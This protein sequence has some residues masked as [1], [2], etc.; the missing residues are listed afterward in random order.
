[1]VFPQPARDV[2]SRGT[3]LK[4]RLSLFNT[5]LLRPTLPIT[6]D[7]RLASITHFRLVAHTSRKVSALYPS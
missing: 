7:D 3:A 4:I 6:E 1:M 5:V 2:G